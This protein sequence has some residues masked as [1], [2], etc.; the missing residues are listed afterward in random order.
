MQFKSDGITAFWYP[1]KKYVPKVWSENSK[2]EHE[3]GCKS[4][5]STMLVFQS[6]K[7]KE[8]SKWASYWGTSERCSYK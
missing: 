7:N 5:D 6:Q 8:K 2:V 1:G 4:E 3:F